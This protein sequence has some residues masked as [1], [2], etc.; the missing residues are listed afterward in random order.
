MNDENQR[1]R[2]IVADDHEI[3]ASGVAEMLAKQ[4]DFEI[5]GTAKDGLE[6]LNFVRNQEI[7]LA[8]LDLNMPNLS[9]IET[10]LKL[11]KDYPNVKVLI[12]SMFDREGYIQNALDSG[13]D[14]YV[15][16]NINEAEMVNAIR[17]IMNGK[18]YFS[19]DV[20]EKMA[21]KMRIYG[22]AEGGVKLSSNERKILEGL[23][24][25]YTSDELS[26]KLDLNAHN[27]TSY[28]KMLLQKFEAKNVSHLIKEAFERGYLG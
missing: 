9:G 6:V 22:E 19:Q 14:G 12:L 16:K 24:E 25:G 11:K 18:T 13:V 10:T 17:R 28:R 26:V 15:L 5:L 4:D 23:A 21:N 2:I 7:D 3:L 8:I 27:V 20:M 1:I